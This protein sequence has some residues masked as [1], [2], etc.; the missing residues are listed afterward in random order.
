MIYSRDKIIAFNRND[1]TRVDEI[2]A[3]P[4]E[5]DDM[6]TGGKDSIPTSRIIT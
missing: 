2:E 6:M 3:E 1:F 5:N 4:D